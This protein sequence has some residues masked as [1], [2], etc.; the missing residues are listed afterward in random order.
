MRPAELQASCA[1]LFLGAGQ[2]P[3]WAPRVQCGVARAWVAVGFWGKGVGRG[4]A[5]NPSPQDRRLRG[6][7]PPETTF[8]QSHLMDG[9]MQARNSV[10]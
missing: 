5:G 4:L 2:P 8:P 6:A 10:A 7:G 9:D 1:P 3:R